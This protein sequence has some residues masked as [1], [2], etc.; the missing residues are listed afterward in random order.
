MTPTEFN[1]AIGAQVR[2]LRLKNKESQAKLASVINVVYQQVQK[3]EAGHNGFSAF[4]L[5]KIAAHYGV[6]VGSLFE[7]AAESEAA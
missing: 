4:Q 5:A 1:T 7:Q 2:K 6:P 3:S